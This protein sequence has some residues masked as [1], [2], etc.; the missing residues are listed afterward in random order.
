M[1]IFKVT[2]LLLPSISKLVLAFA[3][4]VLK[5]SCCALIASTGLT[6]LPAIGGVTVTG[7]GVTIICLRA[8]QLTITNRHAAISILFNIFFFIYLS[9]QY[10]RCIAVFLSFFP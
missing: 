9:F 7:G 1:R 5:L 4:K 3:E 10:R 8:L 2:S 6:G